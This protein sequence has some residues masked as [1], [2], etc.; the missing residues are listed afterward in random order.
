[1]HLF[2]PHPHRAAAAAKIQ[3]FYLIV[4]LVI[5]IRFRRGEQ[6]VT[7]RQRPVPAVRVMH[8]PQLGVHLFTLRRRGVLQIPHRQRNP[9]RILNPI[10]IRIHQPQLKLL[11]LRVQG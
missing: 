1:M 8:P 11:L 2:N 9:R 5:L 10:P 3:I 6:P 7:S 4:M